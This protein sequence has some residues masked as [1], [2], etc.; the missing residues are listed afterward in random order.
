[1]QMKIVQSCSSMVKRNFHITV[2][3]FYKRFYFY[4]LTHF[5]NM[6]NAGLETYFFSN[7]Q[8]FASGFNLN[9]VNFLSCCPANLMGKFKGHTIVQLLIS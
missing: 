9:W 6:H 3:L 8:T 4:L 5:K 2:I 7:S 1:M